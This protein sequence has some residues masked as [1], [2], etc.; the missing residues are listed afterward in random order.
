MARRGP[1]ATRYTNNT[2]K[3]LELNLVGK[4]LNVVFGFR[5]KKGS[6]LLPSNYFIR[7]L[8]LLNYLLTHFSPQNILNVSLHST[9]YFSFFSLHKS[10]F[11]LKFGKSTSQYFLEYF[12]S[13]LHRMASL[14]DLNFKIK[15]FKQTITKIFENLYSFRRH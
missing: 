14:I 2:S 11:T 6:I 3:L 15:E 12:L 7:A 13:L 8:N 5:K 9:K 4:I 10:Y 1:F